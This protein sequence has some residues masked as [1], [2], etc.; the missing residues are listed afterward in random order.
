MELFGVVTFYLAQRNCA[1]DGVVALES[2]AVR[3]PAHLCLNLLVRA[4][5]VGT[6]PGGAMLGV[7]LAA[8]VTFGFVVV[9]LVD[10]L[11]VELAA[12]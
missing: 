10:L 11:W 5:R 6:V 9:E 8:L 4:F 3:L 1:L 12:G 2:V 7:G